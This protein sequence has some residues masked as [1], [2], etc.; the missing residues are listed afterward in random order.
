[1]QGSRELSA[2]IRSALQPKRHK[3]CTVPAG[4]VPYCPRTTS[5]LSHLRTYADV[6]GDSVVLRRPLGRC[7]KHI[8]TKMV[9]PS[10]IIQ[11]AVVAL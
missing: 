10:W 3:Q 4:L 6:A 1:M 9:R 5:L 8:V 2:H 11:L 7:R